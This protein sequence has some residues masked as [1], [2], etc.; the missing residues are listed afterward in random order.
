MAYVAL[1]PWHPLQNLKHLVLTQ[2]GTPWEN[3]PAPPQI[4]R[5]MLKI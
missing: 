3:G 4:L 2:F 5:V 1:H